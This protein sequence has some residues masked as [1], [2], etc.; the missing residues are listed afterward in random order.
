MSEL[1]NMSQDERAQRYFEAAR[2]YSKK[3]KSKSPANALA[4]QLIR[5]FSSIGGAARRVNVQGIFDQA[6]GKWRPSGMKPG[7]EDVDGIYPAMINGV[8]VGVKVACEIK[9]GRDT[10]SDEQK[11]RR[12][13]VLASGGVYVECKNID[14][15]IDQIHANVGAIVKAADTTTYT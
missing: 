4:A 6:T 3:D 15:A 9:I 12:D 2:A 10:L 14:Q 8:K 5:W 13:E 1:E 7:F 11:K